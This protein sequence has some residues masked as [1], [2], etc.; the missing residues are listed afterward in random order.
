[1]LANCNQ[2]KLTLERIEKNA[3]HKH[4]PQLYSR[5]KT[6]SALAEA[7]RNFTNSINIF[8]WLSTTYTQGVIL[9]ISSTGEQPSRN[10]ISSI[11][12]GT[13]HISVN[14]TYLSW[15]SVEFEEHSFSQKSKSGAP[16]VVGMF[17]EPCQSK[18][19]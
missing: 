8:N 19:V 17:D 7:L 5:T 4:S 2:R 11:S 10:L 9:I 12:C 18:L 6:I 16:V 3:F 13:Q 14:F 1:M 15:Q